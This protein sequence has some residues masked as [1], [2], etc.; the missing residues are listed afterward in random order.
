M[1]PIPLADKQANPKLDQNPEWQGFEVT[2][3]D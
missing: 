1:Y 3:N 2:A